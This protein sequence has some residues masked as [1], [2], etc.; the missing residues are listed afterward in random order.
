MSDWISVKQE[1]PD[2][3]R[4]VLILLGNALVERGYWYVD[5]TPIDGWYFRGEKVNNV[6]HWQKLPEFPESE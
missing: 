1:L 6:T 4:D 3:A 2:S 5:N